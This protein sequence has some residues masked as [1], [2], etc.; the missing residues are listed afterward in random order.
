MSVTLSIF[1]DSSNVI[2][3]HIL[4]ISLTLGI[5]QDSSNVILVHILYISLTLLISQDSSIVISVHILYISVSILRGLPYTMTL[6]SS[7]ASME[8]SRLEMEAKCTA[9]KHVANLLQVR[10][11]KISLVPITLPFLGFP[12]S[13]GK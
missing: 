10:P 1:Q 8:L 4:Y 7:A 2:L 13:D 9:G 3:V 5:S 11:K 6:Q 12:L